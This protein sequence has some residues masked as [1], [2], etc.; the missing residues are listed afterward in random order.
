MMRRDFLMAGAGTVALAALANKTANAAPAEPQLA[1][2]FGDERDWWFQKR[3]GMFVHWGLYAIHGL[4]EQ[5]QWRYK[6]P[7]SE[8]VKLAQ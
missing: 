3:F 5:E 1:P 8:Y 4:H 6:V 2:R 7:R